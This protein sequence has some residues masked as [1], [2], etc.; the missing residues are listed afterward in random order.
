MHAKGTRATGN[1]L[2]I[3][4]P[5][6]AA[7]SAKGQVDLSDL[8]VLLCFCRGAGAYSSLCPQ[9]SLVRRAIERATPLIFE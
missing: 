4:I 3:Y 9:K 8:F 5:R 7:D 2:N 6:V 1:L